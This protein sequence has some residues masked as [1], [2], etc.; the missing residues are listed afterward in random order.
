MIADVC[1]CLLLFEC[2]CGLSFVGCCVEVAVCYSLFV[3]CRCVLII[4]CWLLS[5]VC[6]LFLD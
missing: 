1:C 6:R 5:A 2:V 4:G 3:V